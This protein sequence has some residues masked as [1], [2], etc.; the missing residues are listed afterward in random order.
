MALD[1]DCRSNLPPAGLV[2]SYSPFDLSVVHWQQS[3][4][5]AIFSA[6]APTV[7]EEHAIGL[8]AMAEALAS[9]GDTQYFRLPL[10]DSLGPPAQ[11]LVF[12]PDSPHYNRFKLFWQTTS[13]HLAKGD[14]NP[15]DLEGVAYTITCPPRPGMTPLDI[16]QLTTRMVHVG[17]VNAGG[18]EGCRVALID[19]LRRMAHGRLQHVDVRADDEKYKGTGAARVSTD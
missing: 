16:S 4:I 11:I 17:A 6:M 12:S 13:Y 18:V 3:I 2:A 10:S 5:F 19:A 7:D 8:L 15:I 9:F 1:K 14:D